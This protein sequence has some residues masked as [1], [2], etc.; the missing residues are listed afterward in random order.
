MKISKYEEPEGIIDKLAEI[1]MKEDGEIVFDVGCLLGM[2]LNSYLCDD[3]TYVWIYSDT[4]HKLYAKGELA[5]ADIFEYRNEEV[6]WYL[7]DHEENDLK[8]TIRG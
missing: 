3:R 7:Y 8:I 2:V 6:I 5:S 4:D 1:A